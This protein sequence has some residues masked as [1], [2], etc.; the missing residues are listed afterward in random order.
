MENKI[1][2]CYVVGSRNTNRVHSTQEQAD[3]EA[4]RL[5]SLPHNVGKKVY[6]LTSISDHQTDKDV[7]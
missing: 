5:S 4:E 3:A 2:M 6:V 1:F 7:K